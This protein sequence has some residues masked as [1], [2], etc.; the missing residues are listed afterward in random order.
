MDNNRISVKEYLENEELLE[1]TYLPFEDKLR[2]V[3]NTIRE[4]VNTLGGLNT[5]MLRRVSTET[6][7]TAISNIDMSITDENG[8]SGYDQLCYHGVLDNLKYRLGNEYEEF[9]R[10]MDERVDDYIRTET[11]PAVTINAIYAQ[12]A[13]LFN[14]AMDYLSKQIQNMDAE[15][16]MTAIS[17]LSPQLIG[18]ENK[19]EG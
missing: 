12:V 16:V 15:Q 6:F 19:D 4:L 11:N 13:D 7:I 18:G 8:L 17:Q 9:E 1:A 14:Q 2:I 10:M 5:T 3:S